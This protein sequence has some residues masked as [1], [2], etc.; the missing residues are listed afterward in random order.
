MIKS[1]QMT[2]KTKPYGNELQ[3]D[4]PEWF[5]LKEDLKTHFEKKL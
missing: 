3:K 2:K 1:H 4:K 5:I